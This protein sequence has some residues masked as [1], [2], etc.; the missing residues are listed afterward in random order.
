[1]AVQ[2]LVDFRRPR[3]RD[4]APHVLAH[5]YRFTCACGG[6]SNRGVQG[7]QRSWG[8]SPGPR[9]GRTELSRGCSCHSPTRLSAQRQ[10]LDPFLGP[11]GR[12]SAASP[13]ACVHV[14]SWPA[15]RWVAGHGRARV[16]ACREGA[17][18]GVSPAGDLGDPA[19]RLHAFHPCSR[20]HQTC[21]CHFSTP[22]SPG[23][24]CKHTEASLSTCM[25][26]EIAQG[27]SCGFRSPGRASRRAHPG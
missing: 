5:A 1:M 20:S 19:G 17:C 13:A 7:G 2:Q 11:H 4:T 27:A 3:P 15:A 23:H 24:G 12:P 26:P 18:S 9:P 25:S 6:I 10:R 16:A 8:C 21:K 14:P 22:P